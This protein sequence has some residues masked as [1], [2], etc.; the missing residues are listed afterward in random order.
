MSDFH[1]VREYLL[2]RL[3]ANIREADGDL[4]IIETERRHHCEMSYG[5]V[6]L[7]WIVSFNDGS[8]IASVPV[9]T[10][11]DVKS[12]IRDHVKEIDIFDELFIAPMKQMTHCEAKRLLGKESC[13]CISDLV[14]ACDGKTIAPANPNITAER[15]IDKRYECS[16]DIHF[17]DHC[18]PD[19][20]VYGVYENSQIVSLAYA[21]K[22]GEYQDGVADIGVET[23]KDYR[24]RGYARECVN[25]VARHVIDKGGES[26]YLCSPNNTA[27]IHTALSAGY[28]PYGKSLVVAVVPD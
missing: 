7:I 23:S 6:H 11:E 10:S 5:Y 2:S 19:G 14:Y 12:F 15:I 9:N 22:T 1:L 13:Q 21:H 20:I 26:V 24:R 16:G 18:L 25:S 17:P 3:G 4:T 27:S 28:A 8:V